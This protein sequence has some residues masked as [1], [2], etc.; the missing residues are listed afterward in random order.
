MFLYIHV[1][2]IDLTQRPPSQRL[3]APSIT[4]C[5]RVLLRPRALEGEGIRPGHFVSTGGSVTTHNGLCVQRCCPRF[6]NPHQSTPQQPLG[7]EG[8]NTLWPCHDFLLCSGGSV[9]M[10]NHR[11]AFS[12]VIPDFEI[13]THRL[14]LLHNGQHYT[15]VGPALTSFFMTLPCVIRAWGSPGVCL[16]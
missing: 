9:V 14:N 7:R 15:P 6:R 12:G 3:S 4:I 16:S 8:D 5:G 13:P 10:H 2:I 1:G 11:L